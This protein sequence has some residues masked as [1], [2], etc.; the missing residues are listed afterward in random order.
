MG[1]IRDEHR[2]HLILYHIVFCPKRRETVLTG[3]IAVDYDM[4]IRKKCDENG[5]EVIALEI[6]PDHV[7]PFVRVWPSGSAAEVV[8]EVREVNANEEA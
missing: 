8:K 1:Y 4:L 5:W 7:H 3:A 6:M 2:M